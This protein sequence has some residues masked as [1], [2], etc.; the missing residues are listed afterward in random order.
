MHAENS[1]PN[2]KAQ[3]ISTFERM[4]ST[5][6]SGSIWSIDC[7]NV[8]TYDHFGQPIENLEIYVDGT[9]QRISQEFDAAGRYTSKTTERQIGS[10]W[11]KIEET[12]R[13]FDDITG[14][15]IEHRSYS[16]QNGEATPGNCFNRVITRDELGRITL[17]EIQVLYRGF[18]DPTQRIYITYGD[19]GK[20]SELRATQLN[21]LGRWEEAGKY[22]DIVWEN[23]N[24]QITTLD[25]LFQGDNRIKSAHFYQ[26]NGTKEYY[27][28]DVTA[29]YTDGNTTDFINDCRGMY[30]GYA[31][32]G[33]Q[34]NF[35][36]T[37]Q[38]GSINVKTRYY[39]LDAAGEID[40]W[41]LYDET[42]KYDAY[43]ND[44]LIETIYSM[45]EAPSKK[46]VEQRV[47]ATVDYDPTHGYPL[48]MIVSEYDP[49]TKTTFQFLKIEYSDY[50]DA[51][52]IEESKIGNIAAPANGQTEW[53]D[54]SGRKVARPR[55]GIYLKREGSKVTKMNI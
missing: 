45:S 50:I 49:E 9:Y 23:T 47:A 52:T 55:H 29:T 21:N 27:D 32:S 34:I 4:D 16:Y 7:S 39:S 24:C 8:Y 6:S 36:Q 17:V 48:S 38:N 33:C 35:R 46:D 15:E 40:F 37:D 19:D 44:V 18:Y 30:Q 31:N 25:A 5:D 42:T 28:Y 2:W 22:T 12:T 20:P 51:N 53:Y 3:T 41:E 54:L 11:V 1:A 26:R 43:G 14:A 13:K 10:E